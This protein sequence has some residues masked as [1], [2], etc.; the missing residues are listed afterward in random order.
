MVKYPA[1]IMKKT[2]HLFT[3]TLSQLGVLLLF[4]SPSLTAQSNPTTPWLTD[5]QAAKKAAAKEKKDIALLFTASDW[6][7]LAKTFDEKILSQKEFLDQASS[8]YILV[9][10]DFPKNKARIKQQTATQN[11]LLMQAYRV[12]GLPTLVLTDDLGRPYAITGYHDG[13]LTAWLE[14]FNLLRQT[15]EKRDRLIAEA[16]QVEGVERAQLLAQALPDLPGN[17]AARFYRNIMNEAIKLDPANKSG[18]I[19]YYKSL[20]ADVQYADQMQKLALEGND[21]KMLVLSKHYLKEG[22]LNAASR[23][24]VLFNIFGIYEKQNNTDLMGKTLQAIINTAPDSSQ[25]KQAATLQ[26]KLKAKASK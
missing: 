21:K 1:L 19:E 14:E 26:D 23:Q 24:S 3:S 8:R 12:R 16:K 6:L 13:G 18:R 7:D 25:G 15:R 22:Y 4:L 10:L 2:F 5:F 9:K 11:Q 20:I 17:I